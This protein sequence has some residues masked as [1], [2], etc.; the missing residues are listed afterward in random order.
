MNRFRPSVDVL[1]DRVVPAAVTLTANGWVDTDGIETWVQNDDDVRVAADAPNVDFAAL[2]IT[3]LNTLALDPNYG[4]GVDRTVTLGDMNVNY[5]DWRGGAVIDVN[6]TVTA[7]GGQVDPVDAGI[8]RMEFDVTDGYLQLSGDRESMNI[9]GGPLGLKGYLNLGGAAGALQLHNVT[10]RGFTDDDIV[11]FDRGVHYVRGSV[12]TSGVERVIARDQ[13]QI[14]VDGVNFPTSTWLTDGGYLSIEGGAHVYVDPGCRVGTTSFHG[15]GVVEGGN[16]ISVNSGVVVW[17]EYSRLVLRGHN[18]RV[19]SLVGVVMLRDG[20][21]LVAENAAAAQH[22]VGVNGGLYVGNGGIVNATTG[23]RSLIHVNGALTING[24]IIDV[25]LTCEEGVGFRNDEVKVEGRIR[26][27][28]GGVIVNLTGPRLLNV[29]WD[30]ISC[31]GDDVPTSLT[32]SFDESASSLP[33]DSVVLYD[34][35]SKI[36]RVRTLKQ[37]EEGGGEEG[38]EMEFMPPEEEQVFYFAPE[39]DAVDWV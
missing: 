6:G 38:G 27:L 36:V 7:H 21:G 24:G 5:I 30:V 8:Y 23:G 1:G 13:A 28:G 18:S 12:A 26:I 14:Q 19:E 32:G 39:V 31:V 2:G 11:S 16:L 35:D 3:R 34:R 37:E 29:E 15:E 20:G 25:D 9:G 10:I 33:S 4:V 17:G 22:T